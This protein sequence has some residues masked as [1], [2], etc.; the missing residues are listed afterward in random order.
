MRIYH[1][2]FTVSNLKR[3]VSFYEKLFGLK[4]L[5]DGERPELGLKF[6][7]LEDKSGG[8]LELMEFRKFKKIDKEHK[9][10]KK[11]GIKHLAFAVDDI[12]KTFREAPKMGA[13]QIWPIKKGV[14]VNKIAFIADLG[15][16]PIEL[17][18]LNR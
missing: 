18:E 17:A 13:R 16:I 10:L 11:V 7:M 9:D 4:S 2:A 8:K 12:E 1:T 6:T 5:F 3:S 14:T 15:G